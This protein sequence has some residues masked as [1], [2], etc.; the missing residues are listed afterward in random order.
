[1]PIKPREYPITIGLRVTDAQA[2]KIDAWATEMGLQRN[3]LLR[4]IIENV[5]M[6]RL[7]IPLG[8]T[9]E[10]GDGRGGQG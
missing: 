3:A 9:S 7:A 2:K 10:A 5:Q 8:A 1:M 6:P 4:L